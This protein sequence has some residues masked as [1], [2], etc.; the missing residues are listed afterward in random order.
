[1]ALEAGDIPT[2]RKCLEAALL[3]ADPPHRNLAL[4]AAVG[5]ALP[6]EITR[7]YTGGL[8]LRSRTIAEWGMYQLNSVQ[9]RFR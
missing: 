1:M 3:I 2:A 8:S 6:E 7:F 5:A 9:S 4:S